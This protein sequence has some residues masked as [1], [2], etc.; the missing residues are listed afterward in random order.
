MTLDSDWDKLLL[1]PAS[2][3]LASFWCSFIEAPCYGIP[4][5]SS[6]SKPKSCK[7]GT[8]SPSNENIL[9]A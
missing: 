9:T 3:V 4:A 1:V 6:R 2:V 5:H 7:P 8:I